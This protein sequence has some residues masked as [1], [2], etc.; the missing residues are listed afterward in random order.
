MNVKLR[1]S[2]GRHPGPKIQRS[3][4]MA[5]A[6]VL[7]VIA[8][9]LVSVGIYSHL[10]QTQEVIA[11]VVPVARGEQIQRSNLTTVRVGFD[12]LLTPI[13]A[14]QLNAIVG[15]YAAYDLV[16]GTFL[17]PDAVG[18]RL[19]PSKGQAEVGLSLMAGEY[20][21]DGLSPGDKVILISV[22]DKTDPQAEPHSYP[23]TLVTIATSQ[24]NAMIT[25]SVM[26]SA[27]DAPSVAA[28][29]ASNSLAL[30]LSSREH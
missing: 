16:P 30:I 2:S 19:T 24:G 28:L 17:T 3:P 14:S 20:P 7:L 22:P 25:A 8:G 13:P 18:D 10:S 11:V 12:A 4:L 21:D 26:V 1:P 23:G 15:Q 27:T 6:G 5:V 29:S 9:S